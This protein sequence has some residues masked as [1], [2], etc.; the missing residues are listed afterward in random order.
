MAWA[1]TAK[2]GDKVVVS[3]PCG[4]YNPDLSAGWQ[5]VVGDDT[6]LPAIGTTLEALPSNA[7][8][9]VFIEVMDAA[10]E[11]KLE[12]AAQ[13]H[14]TWL[15]R[16]KNPSGPALEKAIR[17]AK[18]PAGRPSMFVVCETQSMRNIRKHL[19]NE[20]GVERS[21]LYTRG[22]WKMGESNHT[23]HDTGEDVG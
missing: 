18:L 7:Q 14:I 6:A 9:H 1:S 5:R 20:R 3:T 10:E 11:Q 4:P 12:S 2:V 8:V 23:D 22:Y 16:G 21:A 17:E 15:H 19:L 13:T